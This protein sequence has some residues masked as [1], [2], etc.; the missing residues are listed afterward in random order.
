MVRPPCFAVARLPWHKI[1]LR[2]FDR[3]NNSG[4]D[5]PGA[6]ITALPMHKAQSFPSFPINFVFVSLMILQVRI[7]TE[8]HQRYSTGAFDEA[9]KRSELLLETELI[10]LGE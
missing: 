7:R 8:R 9:L 2:Q 4:S 3:G 5:S 1:V 10:Y 6:N